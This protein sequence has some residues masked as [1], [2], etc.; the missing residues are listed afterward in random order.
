MR[1]GFAHF[2]GIEANQVVAGNGTTWFI[3]TIPKALGSKKVLICGPTYSD[4]KDACL[5][6]N[7]DFKHC[8][9][10]ALHGETDLLSDRPIILPDNELSAETKVY[11]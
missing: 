3:Y 4:Y 7:I 8:Q 1:K 9:I 2:H 11:T 5:M 10:N 6:H